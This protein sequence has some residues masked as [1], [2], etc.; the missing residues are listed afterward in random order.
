MPAKKKSV[1]KRPRKER[2][3]PTDK[4]KFEEGVR[5][6]RDAFS[7]ISSILSEDCDVE[8]DLDAY[9]KNTDFDD[10][11]HQLGYLDDIRCSAEDAIDVGEDALKLG[12]KQ[13]LLVELARLR[14]Q[15]AELTKQIKALEL[16]LEPLGPRQI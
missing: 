4:D 2:E 10:L 8:D 3:E 1:A 16:K 5:A 13:I 9:C 14:K 15:H 12:M 11:R 6:V 7:N